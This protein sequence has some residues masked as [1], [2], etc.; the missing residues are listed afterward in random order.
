MK[1][2]QQQSLWS[3][4]QSQSKQH[5]G[6]FR[7]GKRKTA[8]PIATKRL[9]FVTVRSTRA[10]GAWS[11]LK[12][13]R[14]VQARVQETA[15]RFR[16]RIYRFVNVGNHIHLVARAARREDF[17]NFLRVFPQAV[18]FLITGAR[19]GNPVGK[20]WNLVAWSRIVEWGK[21]WDG[22]KKYIEKNRLEAA[23]MPRKLVDEWFRKAKPG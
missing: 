5:G 12:R 16:V 11:L 9:M 17:Q 2:P 19:K 6:D 22:V 23:G 3:T 18:M 4:P 14:E 10:R 1:K 20:F 13:E 8:R 7:K 15:K 21:D